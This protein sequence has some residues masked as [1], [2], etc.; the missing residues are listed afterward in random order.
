[1]R[2]DNESQEVKHKK[3][4]LKNM[5]QNWR[6]SLNNTTTTTNEYDQDDQ[7]MTTTTNKHMT[8]TK[9]NGSRGPTG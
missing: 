1:M 8:K 7:R 5:M 2:E 4:R 6:M 3:G 9:Q